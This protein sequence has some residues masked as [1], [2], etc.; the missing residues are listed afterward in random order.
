MQAGLE[1]SEIESN[2]IA[3]VLTSQEISCL[4]MLGKSAGM[5]AHIELDGKALMIILKNT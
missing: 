1:S 2:F 3:D 4:V 5:I